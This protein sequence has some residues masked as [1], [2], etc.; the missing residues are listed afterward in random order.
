MSRVIICCFTP[1]AISH[2]A[3]VPPEVPERLSA[4]GFEFRYFEDQAEFYQHLPE[5]EIAISAD[6]PAEWLAN[7]PKLRWVATNAAGRE[8]IAEAAL[9][10]KGIK[11]TFGRYH[12]R[13]MAETAMGMMLFAVRGLGDAHRLQKTAAWCDEYLYDRVWTLR[14]K[15]CVILGMG[16]I[17]RHVARLTK[18]FGMVNIGVKRSPAGPELN[19]DEIVP[20]EELDSVLPRADHLVVVL[21]DIPETD[22]LLDRRRLALLKPTACLHNIGRGNCI[23]EAALYDQ[24]KAGKLKWAC[25]DVFQTEPLP[26]ESPLRELD[27]VLILPHTSAFAPEYYELFFEEFLGD[28]KEYVSAIDN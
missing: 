28:F 6:F 4:S 17:G 16:H 27:N 15:T 7:A 18:A 14:G 13:I 1:G 20:L 2:Y 23:D 24:L 21:P 8:R 19:A 5:A 11:V 12:G 25:L 9:T 3:C 26:M 10:E 22:N